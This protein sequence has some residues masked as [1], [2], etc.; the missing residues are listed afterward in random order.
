MADAS[1]SGQAPQAPAQELAID[2]TI[3]PSGI[4]PT[5]QNVVATVNL[6]CSLELKTIAQKARNAEYNPKVL[7]TVLLNFSRGMAF[8]YFRMY[9][10]SNTVIIFDYAVQRFAAVI[11][12]IRDPKTTALV[13]AS[14]KMVSTNQRETIVNSANILSAHT[15]PTSMYLHVWKHACIVAGLHWCQ[16]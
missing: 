15:V 2:R 14:G 5:L 4:V 1:G 10:L 13:F 11:M 7:H 3:H 8:K 6:K 9:V 16:K 12:R